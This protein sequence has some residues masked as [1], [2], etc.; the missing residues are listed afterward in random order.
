[1]LFTGNSGEVLFNE[2]EDYDG[3]K[4]PALG[5]LPFT[6]KRAQ[7]TRFNGLNHGTMADGT[8]ILSLHIGLETTRIAALS[9]ALRALALTKTP[10]KRALW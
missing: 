9:S 1:M 10:T 5:I 8:E 7:Y 6:A 4:I 3:R 2:I